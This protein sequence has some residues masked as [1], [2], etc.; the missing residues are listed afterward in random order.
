MRPFGSARDYNVDFDQ[1]GLSAAARVRAGPA[2]VHIF[3]RI[4]GLNV[5]FDEVRVPASRWTPAPRS[6]S[7][8]LTNA[9]DLSCPHCYAPKTPGS[10]RMRQLVRWLNELDQNGCLGVGFG[11]GEPTLFRDLPR[12]CRHVARETGLAVTMTTHGH[13]RDPSLAAELEGN[14]HFIR[15]SMDGIMDTY[16]SIRGR[17]FGAF[18][19]NIRRIGAVCP[20]GINFVVN[21]AT[22]RDLDAAVDLAGKWGARQFLL[23][24]QQRT[25]VQ[26]GI[27]QETSEALARWVD[28]YRGPVLLAVSEDAMA[29]LP[30]C[31]PFSEEPG[32][33][34]YAHIDA[35]GT[36][37]RSSYT[38][39]GVRIDDQG[40]MHALALLN[41]GGTGS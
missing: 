3:D 14:V 34:G 39:E 21:A 13:W 22:F 20:F 11:G 7:V 33:R 36:L 17:P 41:E 10:L 31:D 8:A 9:C 30:I 27:D 40:V 28:G 18:R 37:K 19:N 15:V 24:P 25:A 26:P 2:G 1:T 23:L 5:L 4:S 12:L 16:E 29:G 32:L 35:H 38:S 6:V